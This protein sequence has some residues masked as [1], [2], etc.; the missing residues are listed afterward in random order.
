MKVLLGCALLLALVATPAS[1]TEEVSGRV[2]AVYYEAARGILV[3][4]GV[5]GAPRGARWADVDLGGRKVLVRVPDD[6]SVAAGDL[7]AVR[8]GEPKSGQLAYVLP[9][10]TV[11]R[12]LGPDP[13]ASIGR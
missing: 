8:L 10:T 5:R 2:D 7:I 12:A 11:S 13:N 3:A 9:T 1:G 4:A 6:M